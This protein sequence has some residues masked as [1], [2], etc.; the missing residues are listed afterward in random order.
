M[1]YIIIPSAVN[2]PA[3]LGNQTVI[4]IERFGCIGCIILT[5]AHIHRKPVGI[6]KSTV[7]TFAGGDAVTDEFNFVFV[8]LHRKEFTV[9]PEA[10]DKYMTV[11]VF[12]HRLQLTEEFHGFRNTEGHAA[13]LT[14]GI[15]A[16]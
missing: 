1:A 2:T 12:T 6:G 8:L 13:E 15:A 14:D 5:A 11:I 10:A 7:G 3:A 4:G 9:T 16:G